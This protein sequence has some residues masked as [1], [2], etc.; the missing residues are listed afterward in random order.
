M[1]HSALQMFELVNDVPAYPQ[2]LHWCRSAT[3]EDRRE[4]EIVASIDIGLAGLHKRFTT[5]NRLTRP[6]QDTPGRI[7]L[8]LVSG[9][10]RRLRGAWIFEDLAAGGSR[11]SLEL[12]Y[13]LGHS[14]LRIIFSPLFE[15]IARTQMDAFIERADAV[16][17]RG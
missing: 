12:D 1:P 8:E 16:Y 17:G 2:F 5:R 15:E 4:D 13:E 14:P 3:I 11:V 7:D 10:F 6:T 9:P